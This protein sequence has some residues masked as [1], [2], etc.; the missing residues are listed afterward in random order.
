MVSRL[1]GR[2]AQVLYR[3]PQILLI[4]TGAGLTLYNPRASRAYMQRS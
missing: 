1:N 3:T 2:F 4:V